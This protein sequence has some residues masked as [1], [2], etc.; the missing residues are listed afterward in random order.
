LE[1]SGRRPRALART[2]LRTSGR[3]AE[4]PGTDPRCRGKE[5]HSGGTGFAPGATPW[6]TAP[7][8]VEAEKFVREIV[9]ELSAGL[10]SRK[11]DRLLLAAPPSFLGKIRGALDARLQERVTAAVAHDYT[12]LTAG[13]LR[14]KLA[15][16]LPVQK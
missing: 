3:T 5:G 10:S 2:A 16:H 9:R 12:R 6:P 8:E 4:E 15:G 14:E 11:F 1:K 7:R 13:E